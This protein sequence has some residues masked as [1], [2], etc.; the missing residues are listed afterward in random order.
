MKVKYLTQFTLM[1]SALSMEDTTRD[2]TWMNKAK[3][4]GKKIISLVMAD[5]GTVGSYCGSD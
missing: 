4:I 2:T 1:S 5:G 3:T